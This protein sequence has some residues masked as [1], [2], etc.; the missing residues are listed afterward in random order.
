MITQDIGRKL[1]GED[2]ELQRPRKKV[3]KKQRPP[4]CHLLQK[5]R[6]CR[7][8]LVGTVNGTAGIRRN[9]KKFVNGALGIKIQ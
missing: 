1:D 2:S 8:I 7:G 5:V 9:V 3:L 4:S 6:K